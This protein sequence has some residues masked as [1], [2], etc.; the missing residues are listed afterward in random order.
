[1]YVSFRVCIFMNSYY[2]NIKAILILLN[3][4][5][6]EQLRYLGELLQWIVNIIKLKWVYY[7]YMLF[8][9][10]IHTSTIACSFIESRSVLYTLFR[11]PSK[12]WVLNLYYK[13]VFCVFI[14]SPSTTVVLFWKQYFSVSVWPPVQPLINQNITHI[15][16]T[17]T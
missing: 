2:L 10:L 17:G 6:K 16:S 7:N 8:F 9:Y 13:S 14:V 12:H 5:K 4:V 11:C 1:M 3:S 15:N